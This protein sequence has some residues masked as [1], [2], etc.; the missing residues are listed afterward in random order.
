MPNLGSLMIHMG[1]SL[2]NSV[3]HSNLAMY[4]LG[5]LGASEGSGEKL[6]VARRRALNRE[7]DVQLAD[8]IKFI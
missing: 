7:L 1:Y 4:M 6:V 8:G 3:H 2:G 5:V